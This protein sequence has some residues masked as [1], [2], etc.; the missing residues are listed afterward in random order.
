VVDIAYEYVAAE[1]V[2]LDVLR[3]G[4]ATPKSYAA[5]RKEAG[6]RM[7]KLRQQVSRVKK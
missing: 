1:A 5:A 6:E 3:S 4:T 2:I 7:E